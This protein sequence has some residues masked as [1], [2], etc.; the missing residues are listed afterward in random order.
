[1]NMH[2][3]HNVHGLLVPLVTPFYKGTFDTSSMRKLIRSLELHIDGCIPCLSSGEGEKLSEKEWIEIVDCVCNA[4][5]KPVFAGIIRDNEENILGLVKR[6]NTL[7]CNGIVIPTLYKNDVKNIRYI[8]KVA[9]ISKKPIILYNTEQSS[10]TSI[11]SFKQLNTITKII[12]LKDSSMNVQ[13]F[14]KLITLKKKGTLH[15]ALF[16]GMEHLLMDSKGCDGY[17]L[18]LLNTEPQ[19]CKKMFQKQDKSTN[20]KIILTFWKQNLGGHWY[21]SIKALLYERKILISSEEVD[22][23]IKPL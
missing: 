3:Q 16:Q 18:S 7:S 12:A 10:I 20:K 17:V 6:A 9:K 1:M 4:T 15:M 5:K 19:L 8:E 11:A 2:K 13:L 14:Q 21:S 22:P 23:L